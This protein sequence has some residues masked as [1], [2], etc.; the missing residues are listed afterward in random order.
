MGEAMRRHH[1]PR[2]VRE[3]LCSSVT[4]EAWPKGGV[5]ASARQTPVVVQSGGGGDSGCGFV[6][7]G[8]VENSFSFCSGGTLL[9]WMKLPP[10]P[11]ALCSE[12]FGSFVGIRLLERD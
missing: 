1:T 8:I 6:L 3:R 2:S 4:G 7:W 9:E 11:N 10:P 5:P 12:G